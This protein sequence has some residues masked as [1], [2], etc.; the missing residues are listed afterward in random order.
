MNKKHSNSASTNLNTPTPKKQ[1][2]NKQ[3]TPGKNTAGNGTASCRKQKTPNSQNNANGKLHGGTKINS[4]GI[5]EAGA[6]PKYAGA[7]FQTAPLPSQLPSIPSTWVSSSF[8]SNGSPSIPTTLIGSPGTIPGNTGDQS[9]SRSGP[10]MNL[11]PTPI[12]QSNQPYFYPPQNVPMQ[13]Y[14]VLHQQPSQFV[15]QGPVLY[16]QPNQVKNHE[17]Y[18]TTQQPQQ[19]QVQQGGVNYHEQQIHGYPP[20]G[21]VNNFQQHPKASYIPS[22]SASSVSRSSANHVCDDGNDILSKNLKN[23]LGL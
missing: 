15:I 5:E 20:L 17:M 2:K 7:Q 8:H 1:N 19:R 14:P 18:K 9:P 22:D 23:V 13:H 10:K 21:S 6:Q 12:V 16:D 3:S 4:N 11:N